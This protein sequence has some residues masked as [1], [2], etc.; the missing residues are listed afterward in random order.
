M[1]YELIRSRRKTLSIHI[2]PNGD[3]EVRAPLRLA[4]R[5]IERFISEKTAWIEKKRAQIAIRRAAEPKELPPSAYAAGEFKRTALELVRGWE[6]KLGVAA[7]FV[8]FRAMTTRWGSCTLKTRRIR[9]NAALEYCPAE[10]L[11]YVVVHEL[12]HLLENNHSPRFWAV[13]AKALP[14]Y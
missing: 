7:S 14:D 8:G 2:K 5:E 12:A 3:I 10:C 9:L 1:T 4:V 6:K 11:E 13:V